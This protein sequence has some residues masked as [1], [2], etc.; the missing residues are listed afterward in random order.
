MFNT[1][2]GVGMKKYLTYVVRLDEALQVGPH[3]VEVVLGH[4]ARLTD[5]GGD[6]LR[7]FVPV[8]RQKMKKKK[9]SRCQ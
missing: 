3:T 6:A 8:R 9:K 7:R 1:Q 4:L 2:G 5:D